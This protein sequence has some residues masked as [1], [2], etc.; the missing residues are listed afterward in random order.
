MG[1][2]KLPDHM[3][4]SAQDLVIKLLDSNPEN[5]IVIDDVVQHAF[6]LPYLQQIGYFKPKQEEPKKQEALSKKVQELDEKQTNLNSLLGLVAN[7][8][9]KASQPK[10]Q[11]EQQPQ[12][13]ADENQYKRVKATTRDIKIGSHIPSS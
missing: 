7:E 2:F 6:L 9:Q 1:K 11:S 5:R 10:P 8:E 4:P 13:S 3:S 12:D